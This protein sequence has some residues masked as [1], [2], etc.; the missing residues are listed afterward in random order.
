MVGT[1]GVSTRAATV[2][3]HYYAH[4]AVEDE[5]GVIAPWYKG[6]NG[7]FDER[8]RVAVE[9]MKRYPR[10][11]AGK[12]PKSLPEY[13]YSGAWKITPQGEI[14][15]PP[16]DD[17]AN[18][19]LAQR[20][21]Y[22]LGGL[23]DYYRYSGDAWAIGAVTLQADALLDY[24][25][26]PDDH[27]W[28]RFLI[29]V[30]V[31]GKPYG[32]ADPH[33]MI[34]LD[35]VGE[36]GIQMVRAAQL[37]GN[38]RWMDAA[39]HW[40]DLLAAKRL[41]EPGVNPWPRYANPQDAPWEDIATGGVAFIL[42]FFDELIKA[43]YTGQDDAI[44]EA[45]KAGVAYLRDVLLPDWLG[46]DTWGRNYWDWNCFVQVENV[47]EFV[48]RYLMD[49][50]DE[51]PNWKNDARN[52]ATLFVNRTCVDPKSG[53]DTFHGAWAYPESS[54]CCGRSL[55]YGPFELAPVYAQYAALMSVRSPAGRKDRQDAGP[56]PA[57]ADWTA[58]HWAH[59]MARRQ[60]ILATYDFHPTGVV[61]DNIDG[62]AIVAGSWFKIAH[63]M[64]LKHTLNAMAWM[65]DVFCPPGQN[66]IVRS[67]HTVVDVKYEDEDAQVRFKVSGQNA[68]I[69]N[70][71][72]RVAFEPT[73]ALV[74]GQACPFEITTLRSGDWI[75]TLQHPPGRPVTILGRFPRSAATRPPWNYGSGGGP[76]GAQRWI[77]GY[78]GR[79]DYVDS[80]GNA[81]RPA[82]E[83]AIRLGHAVDSVA[84]AWYT[85]R[86][87]LIV[88]DAQ[89]PELY[90]YG[91]H[92]KDFWADFTVG[93]G[94]YYARLKFAETRRIEPRLR[95]VTILINGEE[96]ASNVDLAATAQAAAGRMLRPARPA[97][98][99]RRAVDL[100]FNGI[101][102]R[103]GVI[104]IRLK[105]SFGGEAMVQAIEVGLGERGEGATPVALP[106]PTTTT[107]PTP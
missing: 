63:P 44:V 64:A 68:A 10:S 96:V 71:V 84:G 75:V 29:S 46:H 41:R 61:E 65:P 27:P 87:Q 59:E 105:G 95:A 99:M 91:A 101:A 6:A 53:G 66:H 30:P 32:Q 47:T 80:A 49:H 89:D 72:M 7:Q 18:G 2:Q 57:D 102:P 54:G 76:T 28:P 90:R 36:V 19:D 31:K 81:W 14:T 15:I 56:T 12:A 34:Q 13:I 5:H 93:P 60:M 17:W 94:T 92:G 77:F 103:N 55:W 21:S 97:A 52:I 26:T 107:T 24:S 16:I 1:Q 67:T 22:V 79:E 106:P 62:G 88:A 48:C 42:E 58:C 20:A 11:P 45:R 25:L 104:S 74:D 98:G 83:W 37:C 33:G 43:G 78:P 39:K 50:P 35:I 23:I 51:F 4:D 100:V 86:R 70:T 38:D 40:A 73:R 85:T 8:I 82:T 9:T 69:A 3:T